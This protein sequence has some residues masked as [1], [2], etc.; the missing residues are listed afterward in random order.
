MNEAL[1]LSNVERPPSQPR[2]FLGRNREFALGSFRSCHHCSAPRM[3]P[4]KERGGGQAVLRVRSLLLHPPQHCEDMVAT[5]V[6]KLQGVQAM[7]QFSQEEHNR[8]QDQMRKLLDRQKELKEELDACE[9]EFKECMESLE[10]PTASPADKNE[11]TAIWEARFLL[12]AP[13]ARAGHRL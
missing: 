6:I 9:K 12:G 1:R 5:V 13:R 10:K 8:L 4:S 7:Y 2:C 3:G 11:V